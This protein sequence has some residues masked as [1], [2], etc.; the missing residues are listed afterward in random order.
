M[1]ASPAGYYQQVRL[2]PKDRNRI[3]MLGSNRG[4][5]ISDDAGRTFR[6]V[7]S[8]VHSEDHALWVDPDDPNHLI[9]GGDGGVSISWDRGATW[10]F[11]N[12]IPLAQF[13][14]IDV[15]NRDP[16]TVCGGMQDN[17]VWCMAS[18][19]RNRNGIAN[20]DSWNIGGGDGFHVHFDPNDQNYV[21]LESQNGNIQRMN[22]TTQQRQAAKPGLERPRSCLDTTSVAGRGGRAGGG[23][24]GGRG[25][26]QPYRFGWDTPILFSSFDS[27]VIYSAANIVFKSTDRG[28]SWKAI[29]PNLTANLNRDTMKIMGVTMAS[30]RNQNA[31]NDTAVAQTGSGSVYA[32]S[33]SPL[34]ARV[35]YAGSTD[36]RLSVTRDGGLHWTD[37]TSRV[38]GLPPYTP[39][40]S[41]VASRFSVGRVYVT[42]DGHVNDDL[43]PYAYVS[44]D[45][46]QAW[47]PIVSGIPDE[48]TL[49]RIVEHP[50]D[51]RFLVLGDNR[52]V[53]FSNDGGTSWHS[54]STNMPTVPV[55]HLVFQ[56]RDNALVVGTFGRGFWIL[57]DVG[58]LQALTDN[59]V[60]ADATLASITRG[61]QWNL[62]APQ[63]WYGYGEF[64]AAN[65]EFMPVISYHVRDGIT[66]R[67][68]ISITDAA[69]ALVRTLTDSVTGGLNQ[70]CWDMRTESAVPPEPPVAGGG[71]GGRGGGRGAGGRG[72]G[73]AGE[74][75]GADTAAATSGVRSICGAGAGAG[76]GGGGGGAGGGR[77]G[78]TSGP[79]VQPGTYHVAVK[80]PGVTTVLRGDLVV[81]GDPLD[82][83]GAV[84]RKA[85]SDAVVSL[86]ALQKTLV[87]ARTAARAL[88]GQVDS[89]KKDLAFGGPTDASTRG[90]T[91]A[92]RLTALQDEVGRVL[93]ACG[94]LMR[95]IESFPSA[96]TVD[97]RQQIAWAYEDAT[98]AIAGLNRAVQV[99]IPAL[100]AQYTKVQWTRKVQPVALPVKKP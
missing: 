5:W 77:G 31:R 59:A 6:D 51:P 56:A 58:P 87:N 7:F 13:Y 57:D 41:V 81:Q 16:Y 75:A 24:G 22:Y 42:F 18:A 17:G 96:P 64:F 37:V 94:A 27:R 12:N 80:I 20:S 35:L 45:F 53:H 84:D 30:L 28:G 100:Y 49:A 76:G 46:G 4:F 67:A 66:G 83:L 85:R 47:K 36:G 19:V 69:G 92:I 48:T 2:D 72:A 38:P 54:L 71:R 88:V 1:I 21:F 95:P 23:G 44:D 97:Q 99:E 11:R 8:N 43:K 3:Y 25:G 68:E 82:N 78:S 50:R 93:N 29:S 70:V 62:Y 63:A 89:I 98:K 79:L 10:D 15:D 90:D 33:E 39:V 74:S 34:D 60:K 14:E 73:G 9:V 61:R 40:T 86:Y 26:P 32:L 91:L 55:G 52:G 65:P